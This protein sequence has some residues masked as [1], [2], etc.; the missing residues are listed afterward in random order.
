MLKYL[1]NNLIKFRKIVLILTICFILVLLMN[2]FSMKKETKLSTSKTKK[3]NINNLIKE[4]AIKYQPKFDW[5]KNN[6]FDMTLTAESAIVIDQETGQVI[7]NKEVHKQLPPASITKVLTLI[8]VLENIKTDKL[9]TVSQQ[10]ADTQ[11]NKIVMKAGEKMKV[12]DLLYGLMMISANDAAEVL[13]ECYDGGRDK[14]I[15]KMN[16]KIR[17]L[18]LSDSVFKDPNGLNDV[19]QV[20]SAYDIGTVTRYGLLTQ[21]KLLEYMGRKDDYSVFPSDQNESHYWYQIS[22]LLSSYVGMEGAKTG[23]THIAKNTYIGIASRDGQRI[24]IVYFAAQ[25]TTSDA[26]ALLDYGFSVKPKI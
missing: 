24:I 22:N 8:T 13:A 11:P 6:T 17:L 16:E 19:D 26:T 21:P 20:S 3:S 10:A 5:I 23:Y 12:D 7:Y 25:T 14:F 15:A 1:I 9:C 2:I 18:G 4:N